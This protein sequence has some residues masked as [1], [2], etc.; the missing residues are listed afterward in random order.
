MIGKD[1]MRTYEIFLR[2]RYDDFDRYVDIEKDIPELGTF[3]TISARELYELHMMT[4][5]V[6]LQFNTPY[7]ETCVD[8]FECEHKV[9]L[10]DV[11]H[12]IRFDITLAA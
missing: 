12:G 5:Y 6:D 4:V 10:E 2:R 8:P 11:E 9:V 3:V 1:D 7:L